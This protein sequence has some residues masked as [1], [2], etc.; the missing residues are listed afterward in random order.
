MEGLLDGMPIL[1]REENRIPALARDLQR[2]VGLAHLIDQGVQPF[3]GF[4]R[5]NTCQLEPP[6]RT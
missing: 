2:L 3:A 6:V 4:C 5:R 1:F